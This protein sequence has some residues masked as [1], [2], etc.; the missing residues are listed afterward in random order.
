MKHFSP[1]ALGL[2]VSGTAAYP[3]LLTS[4]LLGELTDLGQNAVKALKDQSGQSSSSFDAATQLVDV[5]GIHRWEA[6]G[7]NDARGPCPGLNALANHGYLPRNG[8]ASIVQLTIATNQVYGMGLDLGTILS[9]Y[10]AAFDGTLVSWSIGG[11]EHTGIGGSHNNYETDSSPM[12][13]DLN[14]YGSNVNLIVSQF[15]ELYSMQTD[16]ATA[17]YDLDVLGAFRSTRYYESVAKNPFFFYGPFTGTTVSQ[18]AFSFIYRFMANHTS[19]NPEGVLDQSV[20]KSFFS[21]SGSGSDLT[22]TP[23]HERIP[24]NWYRRSVTSPYGLI[25]LATDID[26]LS[27]KYPFIGVPGCNNGQINTFSQINQANTSLSHYNFTNPTDSFCYGI[28]SALTAAAEVP[29]ADSIIDQLLLPLQN[30]LS[31]PVVSGSTGPVGQECPGYSTYGGPTGK[32][33]PGAVQS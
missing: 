14:Q 23:G 19:A 13:G 5:S 7:P 4:S 3:Q 28:A 33:A 20:L 22:W 32:I 12:R 11:K 8:Y 18:A 30:S 24:S 31:C 10:G 17:N 25:Q 2:L 21:V 16:A 6:P 26:T 29:V 15:Q 27:V 1:L 9:A